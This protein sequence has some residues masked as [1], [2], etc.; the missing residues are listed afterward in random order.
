MSD[1]Q[2]D[3]QSDYSDN[4]PESF[5]YAG[6][7]SRG[8]RML[9]GSRP[10]SYASEVG[11]AAR[12]TFHIN[13]VKTMYGM[14]FLYIGSDLYFKYK[15]FN[16]SSNDLNSTNF[17]TPIQKYMGYHTLWHA[18]ASLLF[19]SMTIHTFVN[20]T[21]KTIPKISWINPKVGKFLPAA[22]SLA[23]IPA[24]IKPLDMLA[25]GIMKHSYCKIVDFDAPE[26][27]H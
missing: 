27:H 19:P 24:I 12:G 21:R 13:F 5:K 26:S 20:L 16:S 1:N 23:I 3:N 15:D 4:V 11:E 18:Q 2:S 25:D 22:L 9:S 10:L 6:P 7:I 8:F 14:T 17:M